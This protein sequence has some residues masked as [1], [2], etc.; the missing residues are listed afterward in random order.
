MS[1][2]D[3][4]ELFAAPAV[5]PSDPAAPAET[6]QPLRWSL[7]P[8]EMTVGEDLENRQKLRLNQSCRRTTF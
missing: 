7:T 5:A 3:G 4:F 2:E 6:P 8:Q 1:L